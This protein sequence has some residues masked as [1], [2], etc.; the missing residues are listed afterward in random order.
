MNQPRKINW[1]LDHAPVELFLRTAKAF[2]KRIRELTNNEIQVEMYTNE[3]Y[4]A[5]FGTTKETTDAM[6]LLNSGAIQMTQTQICKVGQWYNPDFFALEMPFLFDSHEHATRVLDGAIGK[7]LLDSVEKNT[8]SKGLA[9]TYSGG[10][11]VF[12][13]TEAITTA[14]DL[15]GLTCVTD[16]NPV[17]VDTAK[18]FGLNVIPYVDASLQGDRAHEKIEVY[19]ASQARE[20]TLPRYEAEAYHAGHSHIGVTNH[21]MYL[22]TILVNKDFYDTL[23]TE[24]QAAMDQVAKEVAIME[25]EWSVADA[26]TLATDTAKHAEMG[27]I[28]NELNATEIAKL[29]EVAE[30]LYNKYRAIFSPLLID[31]IRSA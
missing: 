15:K 2:D 22:T 27:I 12:A 10:Y 26:E 13:S 24:Q 17:R 23:T 20:T 8:S 1:L 19:E 3:E 28:Y 5:K 7:G 21:S 16:L 25:R 6:L 31:N 18:V 14:E 9:F 11:R 4:Q 29:K 30:P